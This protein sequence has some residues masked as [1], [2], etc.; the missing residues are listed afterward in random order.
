MRLREP[1]AA[2]F[3]L[4]MVYPL[5]EKRL[6]EFCARFDTVFVVEESEGFI[7]QEMSSFGITGVIGKER[8]TNIGELSADLVAAGLKGTPPPADLGGEVTILP[9]PPVLCAGCPH[10]GV[11]KTLKRLGVLVTGSVRRPIAGTSSRS[12]QTW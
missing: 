5:P 12:S 10:R 9:R 7:Q 4:G 6:K 8:F 1:E 3:K 2:V 11:F